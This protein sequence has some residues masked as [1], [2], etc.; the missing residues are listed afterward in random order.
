M[1]GAQALAALAYGTESVQAVDKI[2]GP[3]NAYVAEAKRQLFGHVGIDMIAGPSEILILA[4]ENANPQW[5]AVDL[6]SQ[7][8]H[9][10]D[11]QSILMTPSA[12]LAETICLYV[13]MELQSLPREEIARASWEKN[14]A[15]ILL[16]NLEEAPASD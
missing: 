1:G 2:F 8:E 5:A 12:E 6:L 15:V 3:G 13:E 4:D 16:K 10:K 7:A 14:G 11:A 9:D